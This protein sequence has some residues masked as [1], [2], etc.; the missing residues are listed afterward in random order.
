MSNPPRQH[1]NAVSMRMGTSAGTA[2]A[3][4]PKWLEIALA[5]LGNMHLI[6]EVP[7]GGQ[8]RR[9][10]GGAFLRAMTSEALPESP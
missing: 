2:R 4:R 5:T 1:L 10:S 9:Q 3:C 8:T 6:D 7:A